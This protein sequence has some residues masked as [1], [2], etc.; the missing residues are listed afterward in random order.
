MVTN[1]DQ[2]IEALGLKAKTFNGALEHLG[3]LSVGYLACSWFGL[4]FQQHH[5]N[6]RFRQENGKRGADREQRLGE[7]D[8]KQ[9]QSWPRSDSAE[10]RLQTTNKV[11]F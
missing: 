5:Q 11:R 8:L 6:F 3:M 4:L 7:R 10:R 9:V 2:V 1:G